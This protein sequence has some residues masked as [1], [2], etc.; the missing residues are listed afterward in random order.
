MD[1]YNKASVLISYF[2]L[3]LLI[4]FDAITSNYK[5]QHRATVKLHD[6]INDSLAK[7]NY[8]IDQLLNLINF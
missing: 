1:N 8:M 4:G 2:T 3:S 5:S 6:S 7:S